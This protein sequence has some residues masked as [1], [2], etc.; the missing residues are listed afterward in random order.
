[1]ELPPLP[2]A[3]SASGGSFSPASRSAGVMSILNPTEPDD[4]PQGRR[5]KASQMDPLHPSMSVLP[6]LATGNQPPYSTSRT[7]TPSSM[8]MAGSTGSLG[9]RPPRRI[10]TPRS[11]SLHRAASLKQLHNPPSGTYSAHSA[12][13]AVSP[14]SRTYAVE[15]GTSGAPPLPT[16]PAALRQSYGFPAPAPAPSAQP[17]GRRASSG[18][19]PRGVR[20]T[21]ESTSPRSSYSSYSQAGQASPAAYAAGTSSMPTL[22]AAY[23]SASD[24]QISGPASAPGSVGP[25]RQ[26]AMGFPLSSSGGQNV[27]QMMTLETTSGTV[28]LPV[29]VQAASRVADE[30]RRRNAGASARFR[31]RRKEKEKEA[32]TTISRLEQQ[33]KELSEDMDFYKRERDYFAGVLLQVPGG[34]RHFPRPQSPRH[35]RASSL[36]AIAGAGNAG[37]IPIQEQAARSPED[38][39]NVRRRTSTLSLPP[40]PPQ[41]QGQ[42]PGPPA[43]PSTYGSQNY[44]QPLAPQPPHP[45]LHQGGPLP[46]PLTR[47]HLSGPP[48]PPAPPQLMQAPPQTGPWNPYA[49]RK[50]PES[51]NRGRDGR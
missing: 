21:S 7:S 10:L 6:P 19:P 50:P 13:F 24:P 41:V 27:Y 3:P 16:P 12:P 26:R 18:A 23:S 46:S 34:D 42:L 37:Y 28:Q 43:Y 11:P 30:K 20:P 15:P 44:M 2:Q 48:P 29:D 40:P 8:G 38:G 32:S 5:R 22:S 17:T 33:V 36:G 4:T 49:E 25:D 51:S 9:D 14:R 35:R 39:R 31:Q 45:S 47:S 1:M